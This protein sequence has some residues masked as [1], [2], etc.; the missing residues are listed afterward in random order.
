VSAS[1]LMV[2]AIVAALV[3]LFAATRSK[4]GFL[5]IVARLGVSLLPAAAAFWAAGYLTYEATSSNPVAMAVAVI[6]GFG[7]FGLS[8]W[9]L[10]RAPAQAPALRSNAEPGLATTAP[11]YRVTV[12][13]ESQAGPADVFISY[14][15]EERSEVV[16]IAKRLEALKL[17]VWFDAELRSGTSFDAEIDRQV[18]RAKCVLVCWS[19]GATESDWVRSE[20]T[21]GRQRNVLA[22]AILKPCELPTPFN[23]VHAEDL[24]GGIDGRPTEW[25][26]LVERIGMLVGRAGLGPFVALGPSPTPSVLAQWM[27]E[28][29]AD[30]LFDEAAARLKGA[31]G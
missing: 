8:A 11:S 27:A 31:R 26:R 4:R 21:V 10:L 19:P 25:I 22:A 9:L 15:R 14:K 17:K 18:R 13:T 16:D 7:A 24:S 1:L 3:A 6:C 28:Y 29:P 23:L 12:P 5:F 2:L 20:A 30:L